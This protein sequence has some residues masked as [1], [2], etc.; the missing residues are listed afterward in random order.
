MSSHR[1]LRLSTRETK[2][3][4]E[5]KESKTSI[6]GLTLN[7][8]ESKHHRTVSESKRADLSIDSSSSSSFSSTKSRPPRPVSGLRIAAKPATS[9]TSS[10]RS[11]SNRSGNGSHAGLSNK[12]AN[13]NPQQ[14]LRLKT[15]MNLNLQLNFANLHN[16]NDSNMT[17]NSDLVAVSPLETGRTPRVISDDDDSDL[18]F[19]TPRDE[20]G[21]CF[22]IGPEGMVKVPHSV[23][24]SLHP[25]QRPTSSTGSYAQ[26]TNNANVSVDDFLRLRKLGGGAG[27][28]VW[29]AIHKR[30]LQLVA[31]KVIDYTKAATQKQRRIEI[32]REL[33]ILHPNF[34]PMGKPN[35]KPKDYCNQL[36]SFHG[37]YTTERFLTMILEFMPLGSLADC[38][39]K[40]L[41]MQDMALRLVARRVL[42]GLNY[43][44]SHGVLHRDIKPGN[45]LV[46]RRGKVKIADFGLAVKLQQYKRDNLNV[47]M[48]GTMQFMSFERLERELPPDQNSF[49]S[50]VWS[51]GITIYCL[52][53]GKKTPFENVGNK[54]LSLLRHLEKHN[55]ID[56]MVGNPAYS[57]ELI[58][59]LQ[60]CL[61]KNP[62]DRGTVQELLDHP[63]VDSKKIDVS[64]V[65][66][67]VQPR[68]KK[69]PEKEL[70][71]IVDCMA[72]TFAHSKQE[73]ERN[74]SRARHASSLVASPDRS[75]NRR[76]SSESKYQKGKLQHLAYVSLAHTLK[77]VLGCWFF[78][79][80]CCQYIT[81]CLFVR[82]GLQKLS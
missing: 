33:T 69:D 41:A 74:Y 63:F 39:N 53:I 12:S 46:G 57:P 10:S 5:S 15:K 14:Q 4:K 25:V 43:L 48:K 1:R 50:D 67:Y 38:L 59:F 6:A 13:K 30:F 55:P 44:H 17:S 61:H 2:E 80:L 42:Q 65:H 58:S 56:D 36:V 78:K 31:L 32:E 8:S 40:G 73:A 64:K 18:S 29:L 66:F 26:G 81:S 37:A 19:Y 76:L 28:S 24:G 47:S 70:Q 68:T 45:I 35:M 72:Q 11:N 71:F 23:F 82:T 34:V 7:R 60:R 75:R 16:R 54:H 21:E 9:S 52:A 3:A 62:L 49:S 51:L 20:N 77:T 27:G 79:L 22:G